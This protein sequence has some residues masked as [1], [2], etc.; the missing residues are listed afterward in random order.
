MAGRSALASASFTITQSALLSG[1][2]RPRAA[3]RRVD[4]ALGLPWVRPGVL[5]SAMR[6]MTEVYRG[7]SSEEAKGGEGLWGEAAVRG[8]ADTRFQRFGRGAEHAPDLT[9]AL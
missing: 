4:H 1:T 6:H 8:R 5:S 3:A 2:G 7:I 9:C